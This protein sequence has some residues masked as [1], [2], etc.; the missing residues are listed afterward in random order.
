[1]P[2]PKVI[3]SRTFARAWRRSACRRRASARS[4][5]SL[6]STSRTDGRSSW[7]TARR[8]TT[9]QRPRGPSSTALASK[10]VSA[11]C[12][13]RTGR[14]RRRR[15]HRARSRSTASVSICVT[16]SV[17]CGP[18]PASRSVRCS[19]WRSASAPPPRSSPSSTQ[20]PS[21]RCRFPNRIGSSRW[22]CARPPRPAA[23]RG[24]RAPGLLHSGRGGAMPGAKP[25]DPDALMNMTSQDYLD[26]VDRQQVFA[27]MAAI[28]DMGDSVFQPPNGEPQLVKGQRVTA[29]FFDVLG[30]THAGR[31]LHVGQRG[32]RQRP[33]RRRE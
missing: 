5:R 26:W 15:V 32:R 2:D 19:C 24:H 18:R 16:P 10:P 3:G 25:P 14:K 11:P 29:S 17:H 13:R 30:A 9:P 8:P 1:M 20:S 12:G 27:S 7:R 31:G 28:S 4:P 6:R 21:G 23:P 22:G 33:R